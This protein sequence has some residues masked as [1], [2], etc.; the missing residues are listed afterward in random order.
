MSGVALERLQLQHE[1]DQLNAAYAAALDEKRFDAWP[2]FFLEDGRYTL[3]AR[4]NFDRG[5]PLALMDLESQGMMKDR[6]YGITQTIYHGPYY[7][8]H[9]ISPAQV[10]DV[11]G[12]VVNA[13]AHYAV[14]RTRPAGVSEVYN[15]GRYVDQIVR[16]PEGL[17]FRSRL[18]VYDSEMILN[19]LIYPV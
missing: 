1:V 10:L 2:E 18:C 17:R 16:T 9:V 19:S 13:Q 6:V 8:R 14:F 11:E 7:T 5:L 4:E 3:Q 12:D 15:V